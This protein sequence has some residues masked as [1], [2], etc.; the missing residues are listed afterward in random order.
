MKGTLF[1]TIYA[2]NIQNQKQRNAALLKNLSQIKSDRRSHSEKLAELQLVYEFTKQKYLESVANYEDP[3]S[4]SVSSQ[5]N[6]YDQ[7]MLD[8]E[9]SLYP[10]KKDP[11]LLQNKSMKSDLDADFSRSMKSDLDIDAESNQS[12]DSSKGSLAWPDNDSLDKSWILRAGEKTLDTSGPYSMVSPTFVDMNTGYPVPLGDVFKEEL[13]EC[14]EQNLMKNSPKSFLMLPHQQHFAKSHSQPVSSNQQQYTLC[15]NRF[16]PNTPE[17]DFHDDMRSISK[18]P[19]P[20][21]IS[22]IDSSGDFPK[23]LKPRE[24]EASDMQDI[25]T[26]SPIHVKQ[27]TNH[28]NTPITTQEKF[29]DYLLN[30]KFE[31]DTDHQGSTPKKPQENFKEH[32]LKPNVANHTILNTPED[33]AS[34]P[35]AGELEFPKVND[36]QNPYRKKPSLFGRCAD[37]SCK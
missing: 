16:I 4:E 34:I 11:H 31:P 28:L 24:L 26:S 9:I 27:D 2:E 13:K 6:D 23:T 36:S 1:T 32:L 8:E 10:N 14:I 7:P 35:D 22:R 17:S 12:G 19:H 29:Q 15:N 33:L 20:R 3:Y 5:N 25:N 18:P 21:G 30:S 37:C